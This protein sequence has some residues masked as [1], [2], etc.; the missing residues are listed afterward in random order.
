[1][2][3]FT[4]KMGYTVYRATIGANTNSPKFVLEQ[5]S[6]A[7]ARRN[8]TKTA[9]SCREATRKFGSRIWGVKDSARGCMDSR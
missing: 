2:S 5:F 4:R 7:F 9:G 8:C 1:M 6:L 3:G